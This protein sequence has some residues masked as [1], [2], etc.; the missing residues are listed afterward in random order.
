MTARLIL[1]NLAWSDLAI[2][3]WIAFCIALGVAIG[4]EVRRLDRYGTTIDQSASALEE[5]ASALDLIAGLPFIGSEIGE[6]ADE[7]ATTAARV[8]ESAADTRSASRN[9]SILL[10]LAVSIIPTAPLLA[11]YLPYR[12]QQVKQNTDLIQNLRRN[13]GAAFTRNF[14]A[15]RAL[16]EMTYDA[17]LR[18]GQDPWAQVR[19]GRVDRLAAEELR[20]L[21]LDEEVAALPATDEEAAR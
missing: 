20:R 13:R 5:T 12:A 9:L 8:R 19:Q 18:M 17:L 14:L 16:N 21:G 2:V 10:A 1:K 11:V 6:I 4:N 3:L 7:I 15:N